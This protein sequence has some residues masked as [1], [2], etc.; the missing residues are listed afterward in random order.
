MRSFLILYNMDNFAL[1]LRCCKGGQPSVSMF[2]SV[3]P[4]SRKLFPVT[5]RAALL[6]ISSSFLI[7]SLS[8]GSHAVQA[9]STNGLTSVK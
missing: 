6:F 5:K 1:N 2:L 3:F 9:Y 7:L 8:Y 4:C